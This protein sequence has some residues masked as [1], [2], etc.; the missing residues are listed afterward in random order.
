MREQSF[1]EPS[2]CIPDKQFHL[3]RSE[4]VVGQDELDELRKD[5]AR[6]D[7]LET[8]SCWIGVRGEY[9]ITPDSNAGGGYSETVRSVC[10]RAIGKEIEKWV[11]RLI[12]QAETKEIKND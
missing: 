9:D 7:W 11:S 4:S 2:M 12:R 6:L 3:V 1:S 8:Q 5:K 10:D